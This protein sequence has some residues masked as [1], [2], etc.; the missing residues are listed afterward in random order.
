MRALTQKLFFLLTFVAIPLAVP[1]AH[2]Q[3]TAFNYQG[4]LNTSGSP[5]NGS[6][7]LTF[8]IYDSTNTS[9]NVIAG[10][11][12]NLNTPVSNGLFSVVLDFGPGVF[13]GSN[14]WLEIAVTTNGGMNY[15][16]LAPRQALLPMPYAIMAANAGNLLGTLPISQLPAA[17][18]TNNQNGIMLNGT[19]TGNAGG[20][21]NLNPANLSPGAAAINISGKAATATT[22]SNFSGSLSGD[23]TGTQGATI[24][25]SVGG[26]SAANVAS[27]ASAAN[28]LLS[29]PGIGNFFA[30]PNAGNSATSGFANTATGSY[31][32][33]NNTNGSEN[34]AIGDEALANSPSGTN[35]IGL[36]FEAGINV[37]TGS[38]NIEIGNPGVFNDNNIIRIG[39]GQT[40]TFIA[41]VITGDGSGLTNLSISSAQ[42]TASGGIDGTTGNFFLGPSG[43]ATAGGSWNTA[44]G[45]QAL[46]SITRGSDNTAIGA[47]A[48]YSNT[49]GE[50]N[51]ATGSSSL[52]N[53]TS[54]V[55]N[56]A[57]GSYSLTFNTTG[58]AN[59]ATGNDALYYNTSGSLNTANGTYALFFNTSGSENTATGWGALSQNATSSF[60]TANGAYA[61]YS[62][63]S[64]SNNTA[65]GFE[66]LYGNTTGSFNTANGQDALNNNATGSQNTADGFQALYVNMTGSNNI[67][68]GY[69]A[70]LLITGDSNI[71]IGN[72]GSSTDSNVIRIGSGQTD[73]FIAGIIHGDGS[74]LSNLNASS[75]TGG[76]IPLAELPAQV[77]TN[78]EPNATVS[79]LTL[80]GMLFLPYNNGNVALGNSAF[81]Y[82]SGSDN[83]ANGAYSLYENQGGSNNTA[84]GFD[85]LGAN[86]SGSYNT[87]SG[88]NALGGINIG[89]NNTAVGANA[90]YGYT[91]NFFARVTA[92][93]NTAVGV[94]T[95]YNNA[96]GNNNIAI[97][98]QAGYNVAG[99]S[100]IEIG[101]VGFAGDDNVIRIGNGQTQT[102]IAGVINGNGGGLASLNASQLTTGTV[103]LA[104]LPAAVITNNAAGITLNGSF[105]GTGTFTWQTVNGTSQQAQPNTGY[106]ANNPLPVTI[107]LPPSPNMDDIIRVS[108]AGAGGWLVAQNSNQSIL[109]AP[110][111]GYHTNAG[112][113]TNWTQVLSFPNYQDTWASI[114]C[115]S[116][117]SSWVVV[118]NEYGQV[119]NQTG[120]V[121]VG[122]FQIADW[123]SVAS[124]SDG[125][126]LVA[127]GNQ[128]VYTSTNGGVNWTQ[129]SETNGIFAVAC[130]TNCA[131]I[132]AVSSTQ[133][134]GFIYTSTNFGSTWTKTSAPSNYW[135]SVAS[136]A[137]GIKLVAVSYNNAA[138]NPGSIYTSANS[139]STWTKTAAPSNNWQSVACSADGT[140]LVAA[141]F[142]GGVYESTDSGTAWTLTGAATNATWQAVA[143]SGDGSKQ[144]AVQ[145]YGDVFISTNGG[146]NWMD[147]APPG[148]E[149]YC[150]AAS[151]DGST[152][153]VGD[154]SGN[155]FISSALVPVTT[156][157]GSAGYM[158]G[159]R[160]AAVELQYIGNS[161][162]MPISYVGSLSI[163]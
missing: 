18:V 99:N 68:L 153:L 158:A 136:S 31:A 36:G 103:P 123:T 5:A 3:G 135:N 107:L 150:A 33:Q 96:T 126:L 142:S 29:N 116:N 10:P 81:I 160:Y 122:E 157:V 32:L 94:G 1:T 62:N 149:W 39:S 53:N 152:F 127:S 106:V 50:W 47:E 163:H 55:E 93:S 95:L 146:T 35:N 12:T 22:A 75:F 141:A 46:S 28:T 67:A 113:L 118:G 56:T 8:A 70:G 115:S 90:Q 66:A 132:V 42:I 17:V 101:N 45:D 109:P 7:D 91:N 110:F 108:G 54:G 25:S 144:I 26:V 98:Y 71:V 65:T 100:N 11:L 27:G 145:F 48:L 57:N 9:G 2:A 138:G 16:T 76:T 154:D 60:N 143:C 63:T 119:V 43:N 69:Q 14:R 37:F 134:P 129:T 133:T 21:T 4:Q 79:N 114:A 140:R 73:A 74:G 102:F 61:L 121:I 23:V 159:N 147:T 139:G 84:N 15:T 19:F 137:D 44:T 92:S 117:G 58:N 51:T 6:Y 24:V 124:S 38:S 112:N 105:T 82:N 49:T 78:A 151:S 156:T 88:F 131:K 86:A 87:A 130:S 89:S 83:T 104:Q 13:N 85:A 80:S 52:Y 128:N 72:A 162:W 148:F 77:L 59:T 20:L 97:G 40:Q 111:A 41:G 64:G 161:Q 34:T 125:D 155:L 120:A 30:G